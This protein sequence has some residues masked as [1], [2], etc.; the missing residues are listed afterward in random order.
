MLLLSMK[1][2]IINNT[3]HIN[4][5]LTKRILVLKAVSCRELFLYGIRVTDV[6]SV[7][8]VAREDIPEHDVTAKEELRKKILREVLKADRLSQEQKW[9]L[10]CRRR[11]LSYLDALKL[12]EVSNVF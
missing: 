4:S 11:F 5:S 9:L 3:N 2:Q 1:K 12:Y 7:S 10:E 6:F 8:G